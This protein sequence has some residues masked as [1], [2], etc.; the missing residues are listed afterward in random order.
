MEFNGIP[1]KLSWPTSISSA[2]YDD[3]VVV[4]VR[5]SSGAAAPTS[6]KCVL[7]VT[8]NQRTQRSELKSPSSFDLRPQVS[9]YFTFPLVTERAS[10][11]MASN[12]PS[13]NFDAF[14]WVAPYKEKE[15]DVVRV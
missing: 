11:D 5:S 14:F 1:S 4:V 12:S 6:K 8:V 3:V 7:G 10:V 13:K 9:A 2:S 15:L